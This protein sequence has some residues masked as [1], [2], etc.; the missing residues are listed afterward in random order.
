MVSRRHAQQFM[1]GE[2]DL[3]K[4]LWQN[5]RLNHLLLLLLPQG[6]SPRASIR[7]PSTH[8]A[9]LGFFYSDLWSV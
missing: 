5:L 2:N 1:I 4:H 3:A 6:E 7:H 8:L 9:N